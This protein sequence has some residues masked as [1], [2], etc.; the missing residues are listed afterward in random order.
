MEPVLAATSQPTRDGA[1]TSSA[2]TCTASCT[3]S[4]PRSEQTSAWR[5]RRSTISCGCRR[6]STSSASSTAGR[7]ASRAPGHLDLVLGA[8]KGRAVDGY[9]AGQLEVLAGDVP[10]RVVLCEDPTADRLEL[11]A[12]AR[13]RLPEGPLVAPDVQPPRWAHRV[14]RELGATV[15]LMH[16]GPAA[17]LLPAAQAAY[18]DLDARGLLHRFVLHPRSSEAFALALFALLDEAGVSAVLASIGLP[19][20]TA[21]P[22]AFEWSDPID[23]LQEATPGRPHQTQVDV[24][25]QRTRADGELERWCDDRLGSAPKPCEHCLP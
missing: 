25:L 5:C 24:V 19:V 3:S 12:L 1:S 11:H 6:T 10:W 7:R 17:A 23:R 21:R 9:F 2:S 20:Q 4:R 13:R 16:D 14:Q 15:R 8:K 18:D 22:I